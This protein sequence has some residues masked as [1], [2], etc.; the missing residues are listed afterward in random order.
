VV[1]YGE[2][3]G[4]DPRWNRVAVTVATTL[5]LASAL[6]ALRDL[7]ATGRVSLGDLALLGSAV[8]A[9]PVQSVR[10]RACWGPLV[11]AVGVCLLL[12]ATV[13]RTEGS[14][15]LLTNGL[16]FLALHEPRRRLVIAGGVVA[17]ATP[18]TVVALAGTEWGWQ[19][20][21]MGSVFGWGFGALGYRH[22]RALAELRATRRQVVDQAALQ[23]RHRV[24]R[25]VHD[26]VGH[27][28]SVVMLQL[29]AARHLI[30]TDPHEADAALADAQRV[31]RE[32]LAQLRRTVGLL[33]KGSGEATPQPDATE[34]G[35]LVDTMRSA[36]V[37]IDLHV[38]GAPAELDP[39][40]SVAVYHIVLEALSNAARHGTAGAH[41]AVTIDGERACTVEVSNATGDGGNTASSGFGLIGMRERVRALGGSLVAEPRGGSWHVVAHLPDPSR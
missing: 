34:L 18:L 26:L 15:F 36:G 2:L 6:I 19:Y 20:W 10:Q 35:R 16:A 22:R 8:A 5:A 31:G 1:T 12:N 9:Y 29:S 21:M 27:S 3:P 7:D 25:D 41:V 40:R 24:A 37:A 14:F 4:D 38:A 11:V 39:E 13:V 17:L 23:E 33:R 30:A 32:S 28:L